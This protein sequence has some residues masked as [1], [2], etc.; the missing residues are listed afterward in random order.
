MK[1]LL[2][3]LLATFSLFAAGV[4][5]HG[6]H[7]HDNI[8]DEESA[9]NVVTVTVQKMTF[10]N[11]GYAAGKLDQSWQS[12][13]GSDITLDTKDNASYVYNVTN[14]ETGK[15]LSVKVMDSGEVES[16]VFVK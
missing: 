8:L 3:T 13:A 2:I 5:A 16:V 4:Q 6:D 1:N 14:S 12:V 10:R 7:G 15:V 11:M 9:K